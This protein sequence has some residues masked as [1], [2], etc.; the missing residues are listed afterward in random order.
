MVL[1]GVRDQVMLKESFLGDSGNGVQSWPM[2]PQ[3][4][5]V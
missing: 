4:S 3:L 5:E 2:L 1:S